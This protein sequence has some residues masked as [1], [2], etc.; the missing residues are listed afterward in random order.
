MLLILL[1]IILIIFNN[2]NKE[3]FRSSNINTYASTPNYNPNI[4]PSMMLFD[5]YY[6]Y[7]YPFNYY[8]K[9]N[10]PANYYLVE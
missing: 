6:T 9:Y 2:N 3:A 10:P 7:S 1:I 5:Y 4:T 8:Y